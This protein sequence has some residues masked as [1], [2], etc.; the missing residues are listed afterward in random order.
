ML[1]ALHR[2]LKPDGRLAFTTIELTPG[3]SPRERRLARVAAPRAVGSRRPYPALLASAGFVDIGTRD[4]TAEY[5]QTSRLWLQTTEPL[6]DEVAEVD[7]HQ[8]V[9]D[10]LQSWRDDIEAI[11]NGWVTRALYWARRAGSPPGRGQRPS[12]GAAG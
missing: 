1:R 5:L 8:T 6:R 9:A 3:L 2:T 10:R 7:G 12:G 4:A 11:E